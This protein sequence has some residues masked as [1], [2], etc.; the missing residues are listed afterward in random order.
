M[1]DDLIYALAKLLYI[2]DNI[3]YIL[4]YGVSK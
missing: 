3:K 1:K 2:E 4:V